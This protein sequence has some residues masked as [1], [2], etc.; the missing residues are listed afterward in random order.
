MSPGIW[1]SLVHTHTHTHILCNCR[2]SLF[3]PSLSLQ[4][5]LATYLYYVFFCCCYCFALVCFVMFCFVIF[6]I[7]RWC[8]M[9]LRSHTAI[10]P[11][12]YFNFISYSCRLI[13]FCIQKKSH[14]KNPIYFGYNTSHSKSI[15]MQ[16]FW[17]VAGI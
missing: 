11:L 9:Q 12:K 6:A 8:L 7:S 15:I 10:H 2:P 4:L 5:H 13:F 14:A 1:R 17:C 3:F 16:M